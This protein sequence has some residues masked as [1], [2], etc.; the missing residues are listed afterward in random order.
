M[1]HVGARSGK[2]YISPLAY[3]SMD[4]RLFIFASKGG[5]AKHPSCYHNVLANPNV[6][7]E[8]GTEWSRMVAKEIVGPERDAIYAQQSIETPAFGQ[9]QRL[10]KRVIPVIDLVPDHSS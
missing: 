3:L 7:V 2:E 8:I 10:T 4:G 1:H 5:S 6:T 9:Y